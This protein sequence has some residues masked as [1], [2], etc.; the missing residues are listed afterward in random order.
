MKVIR[1]AVWIWFGVLLIL[2]VI[3]LGNDVNK[4]LSGNEIWGFRV[5]YLLHSVMILG[6]AWIEVLKRV[7]GFSGFGVWKFGV[8]VM[9]ASIGMEFIQLLIPWRSF[10]PVDLAYNLVG[11]VL[12]MV[13][14]LMVNGERG[15]VKSIEN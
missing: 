15:R 6:F 4:S 13:A 7:L 12:G 8:L 10:N 5:D 9:V 11:A 14:V 1:N 2:N 3:P